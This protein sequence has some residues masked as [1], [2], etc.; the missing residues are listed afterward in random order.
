MSVIDKV[1]NLLSSDDEAGSITAYECNECG[2]NFES[3]KSS[4][5]AKC[6]ECLSSDVSAKD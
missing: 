6:M 1:Q 3:M 4:Q 2:N 5:K